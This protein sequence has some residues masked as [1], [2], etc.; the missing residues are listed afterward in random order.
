MP[1][2]TAQGGPPTRRGGRGPRGDGRVRWRG[3]QAGALAAAAH[4]RCRLALWRGAWPR[5]VA[6]R[7]G[8]RA[9]RR[10]RT[11]RCGRRRCHRLGRP[12]ASALLHPQGAPVGRSS[13][14][15]WWLLP[16][17]AA[18]ALRA[19]D[20][21]C[22]LPSS[23]ARGLG[24]TAS[25]VEENENIYIHLS[26]SRDSRR[27]C[28]AP[29]LPNAPC[30]ASHTSLSQLKAASKGVWRPCMRTRPSA[31]VV[32]RDERQA[33]ESR[34]SIHEAVIEGSN[35]GSAQVRCSG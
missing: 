31:V 29:L 33:T 11:S 7:A 19:R 20:G 12:L 24:L 8:A 2:A 23:G 10:G 13:H 30:P 25:A 34:P 5:V 15:P 18:A 6:C 17:M 1:S 28:R 9:G 27:G 14:C 32:A 4:G 16:G 26:T 3:H 35:A 21:S 22:W